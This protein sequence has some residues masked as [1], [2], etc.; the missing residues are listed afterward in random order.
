LESELGRPLGLG[1][2][3]QLGRATERGLVLRLERVKET[4][5]VLAKVLAKVL[6]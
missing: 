1:S 4:E 3:S 2:E 6:V 5:W